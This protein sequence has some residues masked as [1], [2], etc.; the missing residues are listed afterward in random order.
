MESSAT[1]ARLKENLSDIL[2]NTE[3][4]LDVLGDERRA[5]AANDAEALDA[6]GARK[7]ELAERLEQL[8]RT[9]TDLVCRHQ[10]EHQQPQTM[11]SLLQASDQSGDLS[12]LWAAVQEGVR[13]CGRLNQINGTAVRVRRE[14]V[15]RALGLL[16]GGPAAMAPLYDD[17][18]NTDSQSL[19]N[20][21]TTSCRA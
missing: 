1:A 13:N 12:K 9:R 11:S 17:A 8:D 21:P 2:S 7:L 6:A 19:G 15:S 4:M 18:G 5:L 20:R 16:Q 14:S 10:A 3:A